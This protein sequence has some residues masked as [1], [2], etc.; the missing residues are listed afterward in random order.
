MLATTDRYPRGMAMVSVL[1][2]FG[3][4]WWYERWLRLRTEIASSDSSIVSTRLGQVEYGVRGDGPV[5]LHFHGGN[6][7]HNGWF[8]LE[9]LVKG[10]YQVLTPDRPGYL[11]TPIENGGTPEQQADLAAA[12]LD[13]LGID[14]VAVV[15]LSAGGPGAIQFAARHAD[16]VDALVL[17]SAISQRTGLSEDQTGSAL[18]RLVMTPR[19]QN[20]AYFLIYQSMHRLM[21]LTLQDYV[22]TETTYDKATGKA[23]IEK[24]LADP[25]QKRQ[26]LAMADAMVPG[27]PRFPGVSND[28]TV[29]EKLDELPLGGVRAPT[30]IVGS[31][32]DGDIGYENSVNS[33]EKIAHSTLITVGQFG[34]LIWWGDPSVTR[35]FETRIE[36]FLAQHVPAAS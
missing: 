27:L 13:T 32:N 9:H 35:D 14:R 8:F 3:C 4:W 21:A 28:L 25:D 26:V 12:L 1:A 20:I 17:L 16:R 31:R 10:G 15:G 2:A 36:E 23:L 7:G 11:G 33:H 19:S 29:Q 34:H 24:I 5:V 6:I 22:K 18:G 30:L